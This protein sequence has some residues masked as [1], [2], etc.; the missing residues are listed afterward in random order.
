MSN[1]N[2]E[3]RTTILVTGATGTIGSEVVKQ[4]V[5]ILSSLSSNYNIRA[6]AHSQNKTGRLKEFGDKG[7]ETANLDYT[8]PETVAHALNK[9]D[10]LFLQTLPVP[11]VTD[12]TSNLVKEAKK[13]DVK[14]IVKLSAMGADSEPGSTILRLH[15][16]EEKIIEESGIP[17]TFLRPPAF[18]QNFITQLG[19]TIRTQS[20][21]YVPAGDAKMSFIDARDVA[22]IAARILTNNNNNKNGGSQQHVNK[23]YDI[24]GSDALS[25]S[26]VAEILSSEVGKKISYIDVTEED[27]RKGMKQMGAD[28]WSIDIMLEL[29]R[30]TRAGYGSQTTT[31]AEHIIG[32]KPIS[33]AQFAKDYAQVLR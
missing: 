23:A 26:H 28:D 7:V 30:I 11:D 12:I 9:V 18:M 21:F 24:T 25:Y 15:G 33:F 27:A 19:Y 1:N 31:A 32:R 6:A 8:K 10:K 20:A 3:K 13:N 16:K 14:H 4:L 17:Y 2:R 29:F 22:D 5:S